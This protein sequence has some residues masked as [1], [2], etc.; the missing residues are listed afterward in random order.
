MI[1]LR[2]REAGCW[3]ILRFLHVILLNE[4]QIDGTFLN[5]QFWGLSWLFSKNIINTAEELVT[6]N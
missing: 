3:S 5:V 6:W 4:H 2:K 1:N